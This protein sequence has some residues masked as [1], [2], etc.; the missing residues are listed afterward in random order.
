MKKTIDTDVLIIG[1]GSAGLYALR[2]VRRAELEEVLAGFEEDNRQI[3][4]HTGNQ[5][6]QHRRLGPER[7][8]GGG[9][10]P[11]SRIQNRA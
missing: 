4:L 1:A 6:Q 11:Q 8:D 2:E 9:P 5:V 10:A 3:R 7:R